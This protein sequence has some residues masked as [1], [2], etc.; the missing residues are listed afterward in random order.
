MHIILSLSIPLEIFVQGTLDSWGLGFS[1]ISKGMDGIYGVARLY[2]LHLITIQTLPAVPIIECRQ[3]SLAI[4]QRRENHHN[5]HD[6]MTRAKYIED[7]GEPFLGDLPRL[8]L[9]INNTHVKSPT[10]R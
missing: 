7:P 2:C 8:P 9:S 1:E 6:L 10:G 3:D 4:C 5:M